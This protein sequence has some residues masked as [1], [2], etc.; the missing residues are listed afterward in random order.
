MPYSRFDTAQLHEGG[1]VTVTGPI[2]FAEDEQL[3]TVVKS[4]AFVLV[5]GDVFVHGL[6]SVRGSGSWSGDADL[7]DELRAGEPAQGFGV[8]LL[9]RRAEEAMPETPETP[10]T[11]AR[12]PVV[13]TLTW[14]EAITITN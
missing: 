9:V 3:T 13:Q 5:Q 1:K 12:P 2:H 11:A 14:S 6:G 10:A 7:A 4:L 8:A